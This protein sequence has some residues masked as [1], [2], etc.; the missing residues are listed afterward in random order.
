MYQ[1]LREAPGERPEIDNRRETSRG[2][3]GGGHLISP[4]LYIL[5][6]IPFKILGLSALDLNFMGGGLYLSGG[7]YSGTLECDHP[8]NLTTLL[9]GPLF[10]R[11]FVG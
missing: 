4:L 2:R 5:C 7:H 1:K 11:L 3:G 10:G 6:V 8:D 9:I